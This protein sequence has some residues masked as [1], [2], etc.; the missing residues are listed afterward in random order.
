MLS[1]HT[2]STIVEDPYLSADVSQLPEVTAGDSKRNRSAESYPST[3][4]PGRLG[5]KAGQT[6]RSPD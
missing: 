3:A 6:R 5:R 2:A 4:V 1:F